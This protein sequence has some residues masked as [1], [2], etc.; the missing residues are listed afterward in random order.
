MIDDPFYEIKILVFPQRTTMGMC[1]RA[2][3]SYVGRVFGQGSV[4]SPIV[5]MTLFFL[6]KDGDA[7]SSV[8]CQWH[9]SFSILLTWRVETACFFVSLKFNR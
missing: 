2:F 7:V 6:I 3:T 4:Q 8:K 9:V 5:F 1:E